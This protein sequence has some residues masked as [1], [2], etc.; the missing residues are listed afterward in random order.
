M[1]HTV[2]IGAP[3]NRGRPT[4]IHRNTLWAGL[5]EPTH[6]SGIYTQPNHWTEFPNGC[7]HTLASS[8]E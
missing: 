7:N 3:S 6:V 8:N 1:R 5:F 2:S 4:D